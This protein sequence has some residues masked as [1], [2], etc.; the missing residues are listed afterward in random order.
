M[1]NDRQTAHNPIK[2]RMFP[3]YSEKGIPAKPRIN[4]RVL[5]AAIAIPMKLTVTMYAR[6]LLFIDTSK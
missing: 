5:T 3:L 6:H 4:E 2:N 1:G